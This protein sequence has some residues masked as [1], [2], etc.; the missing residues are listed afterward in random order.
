MTSHRWC[1]L[2]L[3]GLLMVPQLVRA[4]Q[5]KLPRVEFTDQKL[6]NGLRVIIAVDRTAPVYGISVTYNVGSRKPIEISV[7][8]KNSAYWQATEAGTPF[9]A[10][11]LVKPGQPDL[12]KD[13]PGG[14]RFLTTDPAVLEHGKTVFADTCAR[15]HSSKLPKPAEGLDPTGCTGPGY[16]E[17]WKKDRTWSKTAPSRRRCARSSWRPNFTT[18]TT[19]PVRRAFR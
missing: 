7:A 9:M 12:L 18:A 19:C 8:E 15:C 14:A 1:G 16:L 5:P 11:F 2:L 13:A 17:C 4:D 6:D 3:G 10:S